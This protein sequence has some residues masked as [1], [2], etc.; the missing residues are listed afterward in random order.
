VIH[1]NIGPTQN[2]STQ[3]WQSPWYHSINGPLKQFSKSSSTTK[4]RSLLYFCVEEPEPCLW[5]TRA[6]R[7]YLLPLGVVSA[8]KIDR[9]FS[10][11]EPGE[12]GVGGRGGECVP[13][14]VP[15]P[16]C[17]DDGDTDEPDEPDSGSSG[18]PSTK[19]GFSEFA[20]G[21]EGIHGLQLRGHR[22]HSVRF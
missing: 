6:L 2:S 4:E 11:C 15:C 1:F 19:P 12:F 22:P 17:S 3:N 8:S 20:D 5:A 14:L 10:L 7:V 13:V 18:S 9:I 21:N 16:L